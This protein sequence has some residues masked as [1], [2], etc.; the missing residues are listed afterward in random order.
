MD[1][2]VAVGGLK[3]EPVQ[4]AGGKVAVQQ[5]MKAGAA[6]VKGVIFSG[7]TRFFALRS[8]NIDPQKR[9]KRQ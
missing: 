3:F 9:A 2:H 4:E 6:P 5:K 8:Q 1:M 7:K